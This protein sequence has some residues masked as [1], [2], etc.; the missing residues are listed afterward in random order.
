MWKRI[1]KARE[2]LVPRAVP[3]RINGA[4]E[5]ESMNI[6]MGA[7]NRTFEARND[8]SR[9]RKRS[10]LPRAPARGNLARMDFECTDDVG[11]PGDAVYELIRDRMESIVPYLADVEEIRVLERKDEPGGL[12]LVNQWR[13]SMDQA[14][15]VVRKFLTPDVVSWK[16]HAFWPKDARRAEWWLEPRVGGKLFECTGTTTVLPG[17]TDATCR[18]HVKGKLGIYPE[19][20]PGVPRLLAGAIR[21][22][23][24]SFV[25]SMIVPNMQTLARGVQGYFDDQAKK[26]ENRSS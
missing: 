26:V 4:A 23:I 5:N 18:I 3:G 21:S 8:I 14:P 17:P 25:V 11:R 12:R 13:A 22:K 7:R 9:R 10:V 16:D 20:L 15:S 1:A 6:A 2:R 19:R 24:E